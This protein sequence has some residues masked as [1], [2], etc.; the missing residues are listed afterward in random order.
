MIKKLILFI[1]AY[2]IIY[3][4]VFSNENRTRIIK[5]LEKFASLQSNFIQVNNNGDIL[6]GKLFI[7]RPG[8]FRIEY[9]QI[10]LLLISDS[11]RLA[12][13][14]KDLK[15]ISFHNFD[16]IPVNVLLF[17]KLSL[18][19]IKILNL[20]ENENTLSVNVVNPKFQEKGFVE[21]LF[22]K[23]P[24]VMKKWTIF[25][26]DKTKTEVFFDNLFIDKK[27]PKKLFDIEYEDPRNITFE[28]Y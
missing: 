23:R 1:I 19:D 14:N 7:S 17:K 11:K 22:E 5:Y 6:S 3:S 26:T 20:S 24:F 28:I 8:K 27:I 9:N 2:I 13:I 21:I 18:K 10:P 25:K 16:Q 15:S 4:D 12:L